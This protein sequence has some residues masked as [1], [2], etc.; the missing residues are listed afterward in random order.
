MRNREKTN[1]KA[2]KVQKALYAKEYQ[3]SFKLRMTPEGRAA[4]AAR[5]AVRR[6][7]TA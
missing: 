4:Y 5:R 3:E 7:E 1:R 6:G 2:R